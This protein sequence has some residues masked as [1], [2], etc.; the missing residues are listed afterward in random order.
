MTSMYRLDELEKQ[1]VHIFHEAFERLRLAALQTVT[2]D[3]T[4]TEPDARSNTVDD[5][6]ALRAKAARLAPLLADLPPSERIARLR[7]NVTGK[8][9]LTTAFG[10][11]SQ[12]IL[13]LLDREGLDID[14]VTLDT[15]RL[16]PETYDLWA[17]TERRYGRRIRAIQP[18]HAD[19]E[20]LLERQGVNGFYESREA[21][22][23]C[24]HV[25]KVEPLDR[26][27]DGAQA[28]I[29]GLRGDQSAHRQGMGI[30]TVDEERL[31]LKLNPLFDWSRQAVLDFRRRTRRPDQQAALERVRVDRLRA[32]HPR[33][34]AG[35]AGARGPL[36][37]GAG[38]PQGMRPPQ[39]GGLAQ[40]PIPPR[41]ASSPC[42]RTRDR[43]RDPPSPGSA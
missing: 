15:G 28:W 16:F 38:R 22:T 25:R 8:I 35:R 18:R 5:L 10:L 34:R 43:T 21:R 14:V 36:V 13:H 9:T 32:L 1:S 26:A 27:L 39:E 4:L 19:L 11:E 23:A 29:S 20:A 37:V 31:L 3:T 2:A 7:R 12:V 30:I 17:E 33:D 41:R 42:G 40:G 24:C 6:E